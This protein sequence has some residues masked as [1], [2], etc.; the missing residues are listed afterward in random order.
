MHKVNLNLKSYLI[1]RVTNNIFR[2]D[3]SLLQVLSQTNLWRS[4]GAGIGT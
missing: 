1:V 4:I 3:F 2:N